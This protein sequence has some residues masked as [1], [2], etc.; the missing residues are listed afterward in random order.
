MHF[1]NS[2]E[3]SP[4]DRCSSPDVPVPLED[5]VRPSWGVGLV[6]G[7]P[8]A[9]PAARRQARATTTREAIMAEDAT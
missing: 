4:V 6:G 7:G 2:M 5:V 3:N 1:A 8:V 9:Q